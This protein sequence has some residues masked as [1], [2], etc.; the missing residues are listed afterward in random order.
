[1]ALCQVFSSQSSFC[2]QITLSPKIDVWTLA[3]W[4]QASTCWVRVEREMKRG[5]ADW[6]K[7]WKWERWCGLQQFVSVIATH[8]Y[9][10]R[11]WGAVTRVRKEG[12]W[13]KG[14]W[15]WRC[16]HVA[17]LVV[18]VQRPFAEINGLR[19]WCPFA[20][21]ITHKWMVGASQHYVPYHTVWVR[22]A[23]VSLQ[24]VA[25]MFVIEQKKKKGAKIG[26]SGF[27]SPCLTDA[28]GALY[29]LS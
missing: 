22:S 3:L 4:P 2:V 18:I 10:P 5:C 21:P 17:A 12:C 29:Q 7:T 19:Q 6:W 14:V 15:G 9:M 24:R 1:M 28:N 13:S 23:T 25:L 26:G 11:R 27:R 16:W 20:P 8:P